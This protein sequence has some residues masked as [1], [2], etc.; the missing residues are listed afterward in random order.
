MSEQQKDCVHACSFFLLALDES[1]DICDVVHL[2]IF[3]RR[4]DDNFNI[5]E[6]IIGLELLHEKTR[7]SDTFEEVKLP[8]KTAIY[9]LSLRVCTDGAPSSIGRTAGNV[10]LFENFL[11]RPLMK[12]H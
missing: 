6:E 9:L 2:S 7:G 5:F 12:Y 3:I 4:S 1:T 11:D 8:M 10:V